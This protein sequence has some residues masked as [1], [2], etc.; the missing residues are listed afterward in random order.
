MG[1]TQSGAFAVA[2]ADSGFAAGGAALV[3][4]AVG[5]GA[6]ELTDGTA[7]AASRAERS[8]R[9]AA[10]AR[11][12]CWAVIETAVPARAPSPLR[13][14]TAVTPAMPTATTAPVVSSF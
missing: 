4:P 7:L 9:L 1:L 14:A 2:G 11:A 5:I 10:S 12:R 6:S 13:A 8:A 3:G